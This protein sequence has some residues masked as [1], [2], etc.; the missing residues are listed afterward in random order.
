MA[1]KT[2]IL[3]PGESKVV[4]FEATPLEARTYQVSV[5]GL[6]DSFTASERPLAKF[7]YVS[8]L[9]KSSFSAGTI[10]G[11]RQFVKYEVDIQ[12]Q[13][14][15]PALLSVKFQ[16]CMWEPGFPLPPDPLDPASNS[17]WGGWRNFDFTQRYYV[18]PSYTGG[19]KEPPTGLVEIELAPGETRTFWDSVLAKPYQFKDRVIGVKEAAALGELAVMR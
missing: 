18:N 14:A 12:N 2:V 19:R 8:S 1:Q 6:V 9:K 10:W 17:H 13:G 3:G 16:E 15:S 4:S 7:E 5:N 11:I